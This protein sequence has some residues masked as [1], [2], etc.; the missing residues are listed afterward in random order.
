MEPVVLQTDALSIE[1]RWAC[2]ATQGPQAIS[3]L[4]HIST[5]T[6]AVRSRLSHKVQTSA[7]GLIGFIQRTLTFYGGRSWAALTHQPWV[8]SGAALGQRS[9]K[10]CIGTAQ[11]CRLHWDSPAL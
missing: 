4:A 8:G 3:I 9:A 5:P 1:L 7:A 10:G 2:L 11:R 6:V